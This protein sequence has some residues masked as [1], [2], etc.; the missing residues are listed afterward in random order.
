[1]RSASRHVA[2]RTHDQPYG[3]DRRT[4]RANRERDVLP[5]ASA[6]SKKR[7]DD[8]ARVPQT[9]PV[10]PMALRS[11][12][13]HARSS[14]QP[15]DL[16]PVL[17]T[18]PPGG[19]PRARSSS[20]VPACTRPGRRGSR[21][22]TGRAASRPGSLKSRPAR[23]GDH[24]IAQLRLDQGLVRGRSAVLHPHGTTRPARLAG[25]MTTGKVTGVVTAG[26]LSC[27]PRCCWRSSA[28][29]T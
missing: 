22:P 26:A 6:R 7:P 4:H 21:S 10:K 28:A 19:R 27:S 14:S 1:M 18:T 15:S 11:S 20:A 2:T 29:S 25:V 24:R 3:L 17:A 5:L 9:L 13:P 23:H 8:R 16:P 12:M